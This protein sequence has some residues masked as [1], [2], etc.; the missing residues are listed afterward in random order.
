M[1]TQRSITQGQRHSSPG[2]MDVPDFLLDLE[3][4][5]DAAEGDLKE[6]RDEPR[7][8]YLM[9][10]PESFLLFSQA[11]PSRNLGFVDSKAAVLELEIAGRNLSILQSPTV[12]SSNRKGGTTGAVLWQ[13]TPLF[14]EW[15][16]SPDNVLFK[17]GVFNASSTVIELGCGV[18]GL[19]GLVTAPRVG[20][21][22]YVSKL[23][24]QN[25]EN[26]SSAQ[27]GSSKKQGHAKSPIR[28]RNLHF[29]SLDWETDRVD[30]LLSMLG[31]SNRGDNDGIDAI[32]AC[33]C[34]YNE[35]LIAPLVTTCAD[36][37]GLSQSRASNKP[38]LCVVAQQLRSSDIF[39][40]WLTEFTKRFR[41]WRLP[42]AFLGEGLKENSGFVVHVGVL[43]SQHS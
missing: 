41:I 30:S 23:L 9:E 16:N 15:L 17:R 34:I 1:L 18:S 11:L 26:N 6:P 12:L 42:D 35:A 2:R 25:L 36:L 40:A 29:L 14:A 13:V 22:Q 39:E 24:I 19:I 38:T 7:E 20:S 3:E 43:A 21:Q 28:S 33:D 4:I 27:A 37:C 31:E 8:D 32:L 5:Q 10:I